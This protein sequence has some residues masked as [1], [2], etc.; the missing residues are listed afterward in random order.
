LWRCEH[1]VDAHSLNP[2][3]EIAAVDSVAIT[4]QITW[5]RVLWERFDDLLRR[6]FCSGMLSDIEMQHAAT[7]M[8]QH[9][10]YE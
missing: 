8:R 9:H 5:C 7:L 1:F 6:P 4:N 10:E 3:S 2:V